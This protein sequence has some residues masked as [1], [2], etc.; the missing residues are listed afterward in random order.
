MVA[1]A[2]KRATE[3][4]PKAG[5]STASLTGLR[6]ALQEMADP[7]KAAFAARFFQT[8]PGQYGEG[9]RFRGVRVPA[10]RRLAREYRGLPLAA[11]LALLDSPFHEDRLVALLLM[12]EHYR[13]GDERL[14][15]RVYREY[16]ARTAQINSWDLVDL[17]AE[18]IVGAWLA[19]RPRTPLTRLAKSKRLW[20]RRIAILATFHFLRRGEFAE[21]LRIARLLL[22]DRHDLIH[23]AVGWLLREVGKRDPAV[24]EGFLGEHYAAM[25]RTMLRY[26]IERLP[27]ARRRAWLEGRA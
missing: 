17:S 24:L 21:T 2:A 16:L 10:L 5:R 23:K 20:E 4:V 26:A 25:P 13:G 19:E 15:Q 12:V 3:R 11:A 22:H 9:D 18:H 8:G 6:R 1:T 7:D 27:E 14:R